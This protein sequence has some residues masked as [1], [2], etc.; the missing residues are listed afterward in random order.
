MLLKLWSFF[1]LDKIYMRILQIIEIVKKQTIRIILIQGRDKT[2]EK[3]TI[4][5]FVY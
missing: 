4:K 3:T 2:G 5:N 1:I